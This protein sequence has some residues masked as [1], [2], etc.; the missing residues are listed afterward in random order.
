[1]YYDKFEYL[2]TN[3]LELFEKNDSH[4]NIGQLKLNQLK[5]F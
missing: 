3:S 1:M 5:L 4:I 2:L